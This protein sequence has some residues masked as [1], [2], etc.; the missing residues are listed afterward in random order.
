MVVFVRSNWASPQLF[1]RSYVALTPAL[2]GSG[3][4]RYLQLPYY[5]GYDAILLLTT[6]LKP[7]FHLLLQYRHLGCWLS[8]PATAEILLPRAWQVYLALRMGSAICT[9]R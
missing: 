2:P 9:S 4:W 5:S 8:S 6:K 7:L 3:H 1:Q